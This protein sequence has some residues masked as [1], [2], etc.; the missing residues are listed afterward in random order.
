MKSMQP[1]L[2]DIFFMT[3]FYRAGVP[4]P[5]CP[6]DPLLSNGKVWKTIATKITI[7]NT[8]Q[9]KPPSDRLDT[10]AFCSK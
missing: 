8:Y 5:P 4:W 2:A 9:S 3:Y 1:P 6:P 7:G 10:S